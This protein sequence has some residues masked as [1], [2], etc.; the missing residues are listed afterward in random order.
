MLSLAGA[1]HPQTQSP[2]HVSVIQ[3]IANPERYEGK[4]VSVTGFIHIGREQ[5]L[6]YLG[7]A[8]FNHSIVENALWFHLSEQMGKDWQELNRK[9]VGIV[10]IFSARHEGPYGCPNGGFPDIKRVQVWS[11]LENPTGKA[12]DGSKPQN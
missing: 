11:T 8:D 10:G 9:Y 5:D 7:E 12:L 4:L 6:F 1:T 3:L 2:A